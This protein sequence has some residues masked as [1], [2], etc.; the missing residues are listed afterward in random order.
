FLGYGESPPDAHWPRGA[1]LA[2]QFVLNYEEGG[3]NCVLDGDA[4]SE[5][6]LSELFSPPSFPER[7]LTM[8][9]IYE[10]GSR[11]GVWRVLQIFRE[12]Q[13]PLTIFAVGL[14][15]EKN[16][17]VARAFHK[18]GHEV[19]GHGYR[20]IHYQN[21]EEIVERDHIAKCIDTITQLTGNPPKGWYTGRDSPNTRR[22]IADTKTFLYQ[23]DYYGDDLPF[24]MKVKTSSGEIINQLIVPY[25][26]DNNDM[27]FSLPQ[28]FTHG[29]DFFQYLQDAFDVLYAESLKT[30]RMMSIGLHGRLI[31]RPGRFMGLRKFLDYISKKSDIWV[32]RRDEIAQHWLNLHSPTDR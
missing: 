16:P 23:S 25:T 10:Y 1:R 14:A 24:Y 12:F 22:L 7:H 27:R 8:E 32:C 31:G 26:L 11:V 20:W 5:T 13:W 4:G 18:L 17:D 3:E 30:P 2:V 19:A 29:E 6:F 21:I 15:L 28:G 9:S